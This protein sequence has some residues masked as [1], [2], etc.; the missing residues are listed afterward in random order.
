MVR[1]SISTLQIPFEWFEFAFECFESLSNGSNLH[2]NSSNPVRIVRICIRILQIPFELFE[3]PFARFESLSNG[4]NLTPFERFESLS[5]LSN[6]HSNASYPVRMVRICIWT[7]RIPFECI[8]F[9]FD[10]LESLSNG[11]NFIRI[12]LIQFEWLEFAFECF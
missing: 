10:W 4:S 6:L 9:A 5:N 8:E 3:F 2:S 12:L 1:I 11:S 7:L